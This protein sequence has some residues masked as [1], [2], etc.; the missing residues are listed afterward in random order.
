MSAKHLTPQ[1]VARTVHVIDTSGVLDL[2]CPPREP[3]KPG[4]KG[5]M[6][7]NTRLLLIGLHLCTRLGHETTVTGAHEVLTQALPRECQWDLGV[8]RPLTS[9]TG[10]DKRGK[11]KYDPDAPVLVKAGKPRK[12]I[13]VEDGVEEIGYDDLWNAA[14]ALRERLDYGYG[15]AP[16][17]DPVTREVRRG[18]VERIVDVLIETTT[19]PRL[20]GTFAID[21]TGQWAWSRGPAKR[22]KELEKKLK[23]AEE[24][25]DLDTL[26]IADI[27][28]DE[29]GN[30]APE[31]QS[32]EPPSSARGRCLDAAWGYKTA[33]TGEK[34]TGYGFHQHTICRVPDPNAE[35]GAE[36]L[37][38]DGFVITPAN[39]DVV[40][41]SLEL[42][43]RIRGRHEFKRLVSDLLYTNL[44]GGRW[45]LP[46]AD[47]GID[48]G[49][50]MRSDNHKVTDIDGA[51]LKHGWLHCPAAPMDDRPLPPDN[52]SPEEWDEHF[53]KLEEFQQNWAF[54]RKESGLRASRTTKWICPAAAMRV[55]CRAK[56]ADNV[57]AAIDSKR[58]VITPPEDWGTRRCCTNKRTL[59]F[60][61]DP[62]D[63]DHQRK[64]MQREYYGSRRWRQL[65]KRRALV[66]G[67]FGILKN[68]SRQRL[69]RGQNRL[70]G[71]AMA[72]LIAAI[73]ISVYNEEQ[74]RSWHDKT[75][76]GPVDHPLLQPD[77]AYYG[78]RDLTREEAR[79]IDAVRLARLQQPPA[80]PEA[81]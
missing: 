72:T 14:T 58:P 51:K 12:R 9:K 17:L 45:A 49:L 66:E 63:P 20:G 39:E 67:V 62:D 73:K 55:G 42:I 32:A 23:E 1:L 81:A 15:A 57:Q 36:P 43:D 44:K 41:A 61:P 77:P 74:L 47:R 34:E 21:A 3:G 8:L 11:K 28:T 60:T 80:E 52:G 33:K 19:I 71:L 68:A 4:R 69:R 75:G 18:I 59:D 30:T 10:H 40:A 16:N 78:F 6:R 54:D 2:A 65:F 48:Q 7:A 13:W 64:L 70:P 38:V 29:D 25:G 22:K 27:A 50:A 56:G 24:N 37:L 53:E 26:E 46:L 35:D 5:N 31:D 79:A 76:R